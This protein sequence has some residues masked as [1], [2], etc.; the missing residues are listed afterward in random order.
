VEFSSDAMWKKKKAVTTFDALMLFVNP[1]ITIPTENV[2]TVKANS[3]EV[4]EDLGPNK[5][6]VFKKNIDYDWGEDHVFK[7]HDNTNVYFETGAHVRAR[8]VQTEKKVKNVLLKGYGTLDVHY[9]L[10]W[11]KGISDDATRQVRKDCTSHILCVYAISSTRRTIQP[12][13]TLHSFPSEHRT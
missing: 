1:E 12:H 4:A 5:S 2:I 10:D 6:Y 7:V 9:D 8:I 13:F 3:K 11:I